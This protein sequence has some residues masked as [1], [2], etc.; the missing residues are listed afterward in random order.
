MTA[1]SSAVAATVEKQAIG[2]LTGASARAL[3][4]SAPQLFRS[5]RAGAKDLA[6][7][8]KT[9]GV[10]FANFAKAHPVLSG[11]GGLGA[12]TAASYGTGVPFLPLRSST[13]SATQTYEKAKEVA[14]QQHGT[15][16]A[17]NAAKM[18]LGG[19]AIGGGGMALWHLL[20]GLRGPSRKIKKYENL[21][22]GTPQ[23]IG[24]KVA[25]W[26]DFAKKTQEAAGA[27]WNALTGRTPDSSAAHKLFGLYPW[28]NALYMGL[29]MGGL[30]GGKKLV[31][32]VM[33][34]KQK[35]DADA[36]VEEAKNY[37]NSVLTGTNKHAAVL[38]VVF[39]KSAIPI[40]S[41]ISDV[42]DAAGT[43][44]TVG[45]L[46]AGTLSAKMMYDATMARSRG[47]NLAKMLRAKARMS[48]LPTMW[49]DPDEL[50]QI[51][52]LANQSE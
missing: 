6:Q 25:N 8:G 39:E 2:P 7:R 26:G 16:V 21:A 34:E 47:K 50:A 24:E 3:L 42:L 18:L 20:Q 22:D 48:N 41:T 17:G 23:V 1:P 19:L 28:E 10:D 35:V 40:L 15:E 29:G 46:G 38:D 12:L 43:A 37:Y 36:E 49:V 14:Q 45:A 11:A 32:S 27:G 4:S 52:Q 33:E 9:R 51:K 44:G 13:N 31:D 5:L 30:Y